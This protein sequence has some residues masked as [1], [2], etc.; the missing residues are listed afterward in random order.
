M[1][2]SS[3]IQSVREDLRPTQFSKPAGKGS[4][5]SRSFI[6]GSLPPVPKPL[7]FNIPR[8]W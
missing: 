1:A 2:V 6:L 7:N 3:H 4:V 8:D 5:K